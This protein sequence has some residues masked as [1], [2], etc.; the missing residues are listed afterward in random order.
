MDSVN[1]TLTAEERS[2]LEDFNPAN[3]PLM[4]LA[5]LLR[6]YDAALA[7][8]EAAERLVKAA[9]RECAVYDGVPE[10]DVI[11]RLLRD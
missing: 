8:A 2:L 5:N 4:A 3:P 10:I 1:E 9:K 11:A 7:R 6:A